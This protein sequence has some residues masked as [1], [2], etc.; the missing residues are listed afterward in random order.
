MKKLTQAY[1]RKF[2]T[3]DN[4]KLYWKVANSKRIKVGDRAGCLLSTGYRKIRIDSIQYYEHRLIYLFHNKKLPEFLDHIDG[5]PSNNHIENLRSATISENG[6]NA[7][8]RKGGSSKY[9]GVSL[10]KNINKWQARINIDNKN[11]LLGFFTDEKK[12]ARAYNKA[13]K[14]YF[15]EFKKINVIRNK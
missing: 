14:E 13:A 8:I 7:K 5:N 1:V 9:K 3:Y 4:G 15:G 10:A 12:A 11:I 6:G 2:F